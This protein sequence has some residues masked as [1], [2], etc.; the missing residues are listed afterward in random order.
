MDWKYYHNQGLEIR[1][2][3]VR[4]ESHV[5]YRLQTDVNKWTAWRTSPFQSQEFN[6]YGKNESAAWMAILE[7]LEGALEAS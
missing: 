7:W 4:P 5:E 2:D 1:V 6:T 3:F